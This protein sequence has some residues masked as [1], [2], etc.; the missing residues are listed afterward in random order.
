MCLIKDSLEQ[1]LPNS[2]IKLNVSLTD[3]EKR[4]QLT[5]GD[6]TTAI[7]YKEKASIANEQC[8]KALIKAG[9]RAINLSAGQTLEQQLKNGDQFCN[10]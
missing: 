7:T 9:A 8:E 3:G 5:L 2:N 4:Q 1:E 6:K 10:R